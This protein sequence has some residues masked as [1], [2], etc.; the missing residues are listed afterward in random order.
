MT[1]LNES[2]LNH[3]VLRILG[4]DQGS[5]KKSV[6]ANDLRMLVLKGYPFSTFEAVQKEI[7]LPQN[8]LSDILGITASTIARRKKDRKPLTALES[9]RLY[10]VAH[11]LAIAVDVLDDA[12]K[13]RTW[14]KRSN[15]GLGGEIPLTL[16][17]TDI[18]T[19]QV[20]DELQRIKY[21]IYS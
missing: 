4:S 2:T 7:D 14:L 12:E 21:G 15:R 3:R 5:K 18:G 19:S 13:A 9:D 10:R 8:Q 16:L 20:E 6:T 1:T 11:V 17:G